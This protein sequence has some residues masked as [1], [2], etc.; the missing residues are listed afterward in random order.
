MVHRCVNECPD[1]AAMTALGQELGT[2]LFPGA[3]L[4]MVGPLGAG[5]TFL[6]RAVAEGLGLADA[7]QVTSPTFIL[8]QSYPARLTLHHFDAYR[9]RNPQ[10][11]VEL[12]ALELFEENGVCVVEWADRC[13]ALLPGDHLRVEIDST[14]YGGR[15]V[16]LTATGPRHAVLIQLTHQSSVPTPPL[17]GP[18]TS[19]VI[20]PP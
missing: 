6:T 11:L 19:R 1:E 18:T 4:A 3:V 9:L 10:E 15:Q 12:G 8:H 2:K 13:G 5:K 17:N 7:R 16:V 14:P 20:Q